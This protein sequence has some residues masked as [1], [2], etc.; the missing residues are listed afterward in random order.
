NS[1]SN[2]LKELDRLGLYYFFGG[3][4]CFMSMQFLGGI[5]SL[6]AVISSLGALMIVGA[7]L[8]LWVA[9]QGGNL[10]KQWQTIAL[11]PLLPL[12]TLVKD[13]FLGFGTYWLLAIVSFL[14]NQSKQARLGYYLL[15]PLVAFVALSIFV[16]YMAS[17]TEFR[18]LVWY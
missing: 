9:R 17:R 10:G 1:T 3:L 5:A 2:E 11:L 6:S 16:N 13:G 15:A 18:Q 4:V 7:C 12:L 14:F 8:R